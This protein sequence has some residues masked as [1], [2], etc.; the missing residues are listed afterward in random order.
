MISSVIKFFTG[1][2]NY[3]SS[4]FISSIRAMCGLD[5]EKNCVHGSDSSQSA[6]REI[7]FFKD[8]F[9][10]QSHSLFSQSIWKDVYSFLL[11]PILFLVQ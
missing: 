8:M 5:S 9:A 4:G 7:S 6:Q 1:F 11:K 3:I 10:G 2:L